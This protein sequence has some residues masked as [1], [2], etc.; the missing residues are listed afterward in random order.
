M[1]AREGTSSPGSV[2]RRGLIS[3]LTLMSTSFPPLCGSV[4]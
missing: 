2:S 4:G 1:L 3:H